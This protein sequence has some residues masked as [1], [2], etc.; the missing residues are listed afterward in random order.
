MKQQWMKIIRREKLKYLL[1]KIQIEHK[2]VL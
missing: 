2:K 1:N